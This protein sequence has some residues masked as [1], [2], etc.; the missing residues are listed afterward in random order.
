MVWWIVAWTNTK[1]WSWCTGDPP[2]LRPSIY[3]NPLVFLYA[4]VHSLPSYYVQLYPLSHAYVPPLI[5][6]ST[7]SLPHTHV[8]VLCSQEPEKSYTYPPSLPL[9]YICPL[10]LSPSLTHTSMCLLSSQEPEKILACRDMGLRMLRSFEGEWLMM[11]MV[12][13][14]CMHK[15]L[16]T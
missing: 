13:I 5:Y 4:Y 2:P 11:M 12:I 16:Y 10:S 9:I 1:N 15:T 7:L 6:I 8:D 14:L 3:I